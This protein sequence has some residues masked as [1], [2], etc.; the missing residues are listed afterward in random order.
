MCLDVLTSKLPWVVQI[1]LGMLRCLD[2]LLSGLAPAP[3]R[4]AALFADA[5]KALLVAFLTSVL[6]KAAARERDAGHL[7][8]KALRTLALKCLRRLLALVPLPDVLTAVLPG[9]ATGLAK[10]LVAAGLSCLSA[11]LL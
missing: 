4:P 6:L 10:E 5:R 3:A 7:G 1:R 8:S 2:A 11:S 9:V